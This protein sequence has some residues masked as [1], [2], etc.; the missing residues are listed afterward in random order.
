MSR[1]SGELNQR[2]RRFVEEYVCGE[3]RGNIVQSGLRAGYTRNYAKH[4]LPAVMLS[5]VGL[6]EAIQARK[7]EMQAI[8]AEKGL[9]IESWLD[10][11]QDEI[12]ACKDAG[13]D[14]IV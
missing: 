4:R 1:R 13:K 2:Q 12:A 11:I 6:Q 3:G 14:P 9:T 8:A 5:N 7:A 10:S